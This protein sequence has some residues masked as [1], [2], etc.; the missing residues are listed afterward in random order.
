MVTLFQLIS[1]LRTR[2]S[3]VLAVFRTAAGTTSPVRSAQRV[4]FARAETRHAV[5]IARRPARD[6]SAARSDPDLNSRVKFSLCCSVVGVLLRT[7]ITA[8]GF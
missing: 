1:R 4:S 6:P 5:P 7:V 2:S 3:N 8:E